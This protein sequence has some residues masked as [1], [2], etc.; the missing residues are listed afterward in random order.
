MNA[1]FADLEARGVLHT[2]DC[3]ML[4]D[5]P[6]AAA[7]RSVGKRLCD[8][9]SP[10]RPRATV[11]VGPFGYDTTPL[12]LALSKFNDLLFLDCAALKAHALEIGNLQKLPEEKTEDSRFCAGA[13]QQALHRTRRT[14]AVL[15]NLPRTWSD[16]EFRLFDANVTVERVVCVRGAPQIDPLSRTQ[17]PE[18]HVRFVKSLTQF[19]S[20]KLKVIEVTDESERSA[21]DLATEIVSK[22][23]GSSP[24][25]LG[26]LHSRLFSLGWMLGTS[27]SLCRLAWTV[28]GETP[29][30]CQGAERFPN[31]QD[32]LLLD[33]AG[34]RQGPRG[35]ASARHSRPH[36][37]AFRVTALFLSETLIRAKMP[38]LSQ[39]K[40][41][42]V[43]DSPERL[44]AV[45]AKILEADTELQAAPGCLL[46]G[47]PATVAQASAFLKEG[48]KFEKLVQV[49][50]PMEAVLQRLEEDEDQPDVDREEVERALNAYYVNEEA[51]RRFFEPRGQL[52]TLDG[53][54]PTAEA[55]CR[56]AFAPRVL[57]FPS[58]HLRPSFAKEIAAVIAQKMRG[59]V[60]DVAEFHTPVELL[61]ACA[62]DACAFD[63]R[64][65]EACALEACGV[66][67]GNTQQAR[68]DLSK[69]HKDRAAM[70][71]VRHQ[72]KTSSAI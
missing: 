65:L 44:A 38:E 49:S 55:V 2:I 22:T 4:R 68:M 41:K 35:T 37:R 39:K 3:D 9:L 29:V 6:L 42:A 57:L 59:R 25:R 14:S 36:A 67:C 51:L 27:S 58:A 5:C 24:S 21:E 52:M 56:S 28:E 47:Y 31:S 16:A 15:V 17:E 11:I 7:N 48:A 20:R 54:S 40:L 71:E 46:V 45:L 8:L 1:V 32:C 61:E 12:A 50:L 43:L 33:L 63:A 18:L 13:V 70:Q 19:Y 34:L 60:V 53:T 23:R 30:F 69:P 66:D 10:L 72:T 64:A 62:F 26:Q